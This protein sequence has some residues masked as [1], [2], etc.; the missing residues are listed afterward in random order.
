MHE[1]VGKEIK[2]SKTVSGLTIALDPVMQATGGTWIAWGSGNAD[3][4]T[5]DKNDH[6]KVPPEAP[7]YTL[8]RVWL[9]KDE[10]EGYYYGYSNQALWP[11]SHIAYE[12][13]IFLKDHWQIYKRV[14]QRFAQ[15]VLEEIGDTKT[16]LW[17]HDYHLALAAKYI[18]EK[19]PDTLVSVFW[20]IPWPNPEAFRVCPQKKEILAGL[21]SC[22]FLGFHLRYHC[23]NFLNTVDF[24]LEAKTDYEENSIIYRGHK[25]LVR[26]FPISVDF[27]GISNEAKSE[28][29]KLTTEKLPSE[30]SPPY[31]Y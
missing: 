15:V 2:C 17:L 19:K 3:K 26:P 28:K 27:E 10:Q 6:I 16:C 4:E 5:V 14:N 1:F 9:S 21:L 12:K 31:E 29:V 20:H 8:R 23:T 24:E 30:I 7:A 13:P 25:T 18:K 22:D 11:I